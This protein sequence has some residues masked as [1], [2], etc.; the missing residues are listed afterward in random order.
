[1]IVCPRVQKRTI[2]F[3]YDWTSLFYRMLWGRHIHHGL[4]DAEECRAAGCA[5]EGRPIE[6]TR[7][8]RSPE[9]AQ[10]R[11]TEALAEAAGIRGG[12]RVLDVG[13]GLGGSAIQ[14]ARR[15][16][17]RVTG[18]TLSPFQQRWA[19]AAACWHGVAA[20]T[21]FCWADAE[22]VTFP[23]G[24]F[25]VVWSIECTEHLFDKSGFFRRA[26][27]WL[28]PGGRMAICAWLS[29][30]EATPAA[31]QR[32]LDVCEGF[33]CPSLGT[34]DDYRQWIEAAGLQIGGWNDWTLRVVPTWEICRRR[35][36]SPIIRLL[37][38][39]LGSGT[40]L[41]L[42]RFDTLL[43]AYRSGAMAYGCFAACK[44]LQADTSGITGTSP[45]EQVVAC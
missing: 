30:D 24:S 18:I 21:R 22:Q 1:M 35:V 2:R 37:A 43:E 16:A 8:T 32:I 25:D 33:F 38:R 28:K 40:D 41:F 44:P 14:L 4:W 3:H 15:F 13:C 12:E 26:A 19:Q 34:A 6:L 11:L 7:L 45:A 29:A 31:R 42:E 17:C 9:A 5:E 27:E 36:A 23:A 39:L 10:V 20:N